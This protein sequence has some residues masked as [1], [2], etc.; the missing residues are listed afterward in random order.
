MQGVK[1]LGG[2]AYFHIAA[3][4][5][6]IWLEYEY[7]GTTIAKLVN[8]SVLDAEGSGEHLEEVHL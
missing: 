4:T 1:M 2:H 5:A 3:F 7:G 6:M 8:E